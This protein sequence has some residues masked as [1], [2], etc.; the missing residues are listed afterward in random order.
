MYYLHN[1]VEKVI[2]SNY[3]LCTMK[4][5]EG[6]ACKPSQR[7]LSEQTINTNSKEIRE[8]LKEHMQ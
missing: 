4:V 6:N 8:I 2:D 1:I 7:E 5:N 3:A